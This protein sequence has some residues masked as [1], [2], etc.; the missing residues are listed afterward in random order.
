[1]EPPKARDHDLI[2]AEVDNEIV[3]YD[4]SRDR[5][6]HL[7]P[8][9]SLVW[10]H[11]DGRTPIPEL[12]ALVQ[13]AL[14]T[15]VDEAA[16]WL[17]LRQLERARLLARPLVIPDRYRQLSRRDALKGVATA[18]AAAV[19]AAAAVSLVT[20]MS[21]PT[22]AYAAS[23]ATVTQ[24]CAVLPCCAGLTCAPVSRVCV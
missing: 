13:G 19:G 8:V 22:P 24:S 4:K 14:G 17:A 20:S 11:C 5:A 9:A 2:V 7:N 18:G 6:H 3:V 12:A 15:S 16:V 21:A 1:M 10:R 23:C